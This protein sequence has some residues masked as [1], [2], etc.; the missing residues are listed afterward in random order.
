MHAKKISAS[1]QSL[2]F[3][4]SGMY[5]IFLKILTKNPW[6]PTHRW[7]NKKTAVSQGFKNLSV[8]HSPW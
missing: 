6:E 8:Y 5:I 1:F 7:K 4:R 2:L 3:T